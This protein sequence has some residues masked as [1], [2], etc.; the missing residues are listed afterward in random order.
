MLPLSEL[1]KKSFEFYRQNFGLLAGY[2]AWLLLPYAGIVLF[3]LPESN[4]FL[5]LLIFIFSLTQALIG[6]WLS[7]FIPLLIKDL[8][9]DKTKIRLT[10]LQNKVWLIIPSVILVAVLQLA[11]TLGGVIL[12]IIPGLIFWV[13]FALSQYVVM[14][15]NKK[16]LAAMSQSRELVRGRFW[17][18]G[19][20]LLVGPAVF[21]VF[22]ILLTALATAIF[23]TISGTTIEQLTGSTP[24]L[25]LDIISTIAETFSVPIL[26]IY[27]TLL[28]LDL[29]KVNPLTPALSR[30]TS[31]ELRGTGREGDSL[32]E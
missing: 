9:T 8:V 31:L 27:L 29:V 7:V 21:G 25:W 4:G 19:A 16:G 14:F 30:P 26:L 1:L 23:S 28:Y 17:P 13:W 5:K 6:I 20:R 3:S 15:E 18:V 10:E 32:G 11:V 24:P 22:L 2:M 12:L